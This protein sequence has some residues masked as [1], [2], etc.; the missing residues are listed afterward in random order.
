MGEAGHIMVWMGRLSSLIRLSARMVLWYSDMGHS[1][2]IANNVRA[3]PRQSV[4][5]GRLLRSASATLIGVTDRWTGA[6]GAP[7]VYI[8]VRRLCDR[9]SE[10]LDR[11]A[12]P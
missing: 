7:S 3:T 8:G 6:S 11:R 4:G 1:G 10:A 9:S 12:A 2:P 5:R